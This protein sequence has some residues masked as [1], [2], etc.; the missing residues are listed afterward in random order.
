M[1]LVME[2]ELVIVGSKLNHLPASL[3]HLYWLVQQNYIGQYEETGDSPLVFDKNENVYR[4]DNVTLTFANATVSV[5]YEQVEGTEE[6]NRYRYMAQMTSEDQQYSYTLTL[7]CSKAFLQ[8]YYYPVRQFLRANPAKYVRPGID[9]TP[10]EGMTVAVLDTEM[11]RP[12]I[13]Q[14]SGVLL[15]YRNGTWAMDPLERMNVYIRLPEG[16]CVSP[17][18]REVTGLT[19]EFLNANG[20]DEEEA[21]DAITAFLSEAEF[22]CGHS[23]ISDIDLLRERYLLAGRI[24]DLSLLNDAA[25]RDLTIAGNADV[26]ETMLEHHETQ[27]LFHDKAGTSSNQ[28]PMCL[29]RNEVIDTQ[30]LMEY[31][32]DLSVMIGLEKA[33]ELAEVTAEGDV[34][35]DARTDAEVTARILIKLWPMFLERYGVMP[36]IK[37]AMVHAPKDVSLLNPISFTKDSAEEESGRPAKGGQHSRSGAKGGYKP[38]RTVR[39]QKRK[40]TRIT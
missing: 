17:Y 10:R 9:R 23:I 8:Q 25:A 38:K 18:V 30:M 16:I 34:F 37:T 26:A 27:T 40:R 28:I 5:A 20:V 11:Q 1:S 12:Y 35:H 2:H 31:I 33:A 29:L 7:P 32:Y 13:T 6:P 22:V 19:E 14:F 15:R 39:A 4:S 36:I 21:L 24:A 3:F